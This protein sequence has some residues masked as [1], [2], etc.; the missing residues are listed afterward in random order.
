LCWRG[1]EE[2]A[3][4]LSARIAAEAEPA[5]GDVRSRQQRWLALLEL[6][7][8]RYRQAYD[9]TLP[10]IQD[11]RLG[12]GTLAL[13]DFIEAAA[14]CGELAAAHEALTRLA[15]RAEASGAHW[16][17]G[18]LAACKALLGEDGA[19]ALYHQAIDLL[20]PTA[21]LTDLARSEPGSAAWRPVRH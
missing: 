12:I 13:Q 1:H 2:E 17:L 9:R 8:G 16:G 7:L 19:E 3:R 14:R 21:A 5:A 6:S 18:R 11:D 15:E 4:A 10:V 20:E